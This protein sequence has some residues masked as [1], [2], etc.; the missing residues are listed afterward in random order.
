MPSILIARLDAPMQSFGNEVV[1][2]RHGTHRLPIRSFLAGLLAN[3]LGW[4]RTDFVGL[5]RLQDAIQ[6]AARADVPGALERDYQTVDLGSHK[7]RRGGWTTRGA[8][9]M[10]ATSPSNLGTHQ[11]EV[12]YLAGAVVTVA[13]QVRAA[14]DLPDVGE[15][16]GVLRRPARPL[17]LGRKAYAPACP[18]GQAIV[19]ADDVLQALAG[20]PV[21][22][23]DLWRAGSAPAE[24]G[25]VRLAACWPVNLSHPQASGQPRLI[26]EHMDWPGRVHVG[27]VQRCEGLLAVPVAAA[28]PQERAA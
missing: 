9:E 22:A 5:A 8:I 24:A 27:H 23:N 7:M 12:F 20:W 15:L 2:A 28:Q 26:T 13:L 1:D 10:R 18:I 4:R 25:R 3:A 17:Y 6:Y 16:A 19:Q 14:P 11:M 21:Q